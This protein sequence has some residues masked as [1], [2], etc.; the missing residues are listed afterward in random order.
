[1]RALACNDAV[2]RAKSLVLDRF[3]L[4]YF[5]GSESS[6]DRV[7]LFDEMK[8]NFWPVISAGKVLKT[9]YNNNQTGSVCTIVFDVSLHH[10]R[11]KVWACT[12]NE[13]ILPQ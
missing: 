1:M 6:R 13:K 11:Y 12:T 8:K 4:E 7:D 3:V 10:L 9:A 5:A 2:V